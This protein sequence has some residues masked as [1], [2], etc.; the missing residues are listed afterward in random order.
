MKPSQNLF[1]KFLSISAFTLFGSHGVQA[2]SLYWDLN[3]T[4]ANSG[5]SATG[6]WNGTNQFWN[7]AS[8]GTGGASQAGTASA[9]DLIFS[10]GTGYTAGG[11]IT[12]SNARVASSITFEENAPYTLTGG[13]S[14]TIGGSG[15]SGF[16]GIRVSAGN[17]ATNGI[18][19][20]LIL[21]TAANTI[22]TAGTGVLTISGGITGTKA[23]VLANNSTNSAGISISTGSL[24]NTSTVTHSGTGT[25]GTLIS[26]VI[27]SNVTGVTQNSGT[28]NLTLTGANIFTTLTTIT[29][30]VLN[31][32]NATALGTTATGT[33]VASGAALELQSGIVVGAEALTLSG[34]GVSTAGAL[35]N[36]S[37]VNTYGGN[38]TLA[39]PSRINSDADTLTLNGASGITGAFGLTVGG[40]GDTT[41]SSVIGTTSGTL[42]KDGAG[43]LTLSGANTFTG[44]TTITAGVIN[45]QN[46][47]GL[48]TT[49]TGTTVAGG[50]ALELQGG[51]VVGAEALT[52]SGTGVS[53][54]GALRNIS[55]VNTYG[56]DITLAAPSRI[57]SDA[58]TLTLN[59]ASGITGAFGLSVG[60]ASDT[61]IS[62]VI[63]TTSGTLTKDGAGILTLSGANTYSG[64]TTLSAG[65]LVFGSSTVGSPGSITS[66]PLG[67]GKLTINGGTIA[68]SGVVRTVANAV[69]FGGNFT[70]DGDALVLD[71]AMTLQANTAISNISQGAGANTI[72]TLGG[73]I[74]AS[75][76]GDNRVLTITGPTINGNPGTDLI[77]NGNIG[78]SQA[79]KS[80]TVSNIHKVTT[81]DVTLNGSSGSALSITGI[82]QLILIGG[83][84]T[85]N[86]GNVTLGS[87]GGSG[88]VGVQI[89]SGKTISTG[90]G[91]VSLTGQGTS[92]GQGFINS[93]TIQSTT[94]NIAITATGSGTADGIVLGYS[95]SNGSVQTTSGNIIITGTG[96]ISGGEGIR[97]ISTA[98][99]TSTNGRITLEGRGG[100]SGASL[101]TAAGSTLGGGSG[102]ITLIATSGSAG[103]LN[104]VISGSSK[105]IKLGPV[106]LNLTAANT[107][108]GATVVGASND[109]NAGT[110][111]LSGS[112]RIS[113]AATT[114]YGGTLDL[115]GATQSITTLE[116]GGGASGSAAAVSIGAG[117]LKL[118]GNVTYSATNDPN[119][120]SISSSTGFL[121]LMG[122]R[123]FSVGN[124]SATADLTVSA[125][126]QNGDATARSL[127]KDGVGT[128]VLSG[129]NTYTG[130]TTVHGGTL[131]L[132]TGGSV[133][134][135]NI[136]VGDAGSSGSILDAT[137]TSLA[138]G[139]GKTLSGIGTIN[140]STTIQLGGTIAPGN[141]TGILTNVGNLALAIGSNFNM[142]LNGN[143]AGTGYDQL[144]VNG[145]V[146]LNG[147]N[148]VANFIG[149]AYSTGDLLFLLLNDGTDAIG[150]TGI[151]SGLAQDAFVVNYGGYDWKISY[152][153]DSASNTFTGAANGNDI[154]LMAVPETSTALL[155]GIGALLLLRRRRA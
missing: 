76:S 65:S 108:T 145:G 3:M 6:A 115:N 53:T 124:A 14:L 94:G 92:N 52:L 146:T 47:T 117:E 59:G 63:G 4:V 149:G 26:S 131:K 25:G 142:E 73:N 43:I 49:A 85:T 34:T 132:A 106:Q 97:I 123:T 10:S 127:T 61:T 84:V 27:G 58:G 37:G 12:L 116:L 96:G 67:T 5:T 121:S 88:N 105:L 100:V 71:G 30:G 120:A 82:D 137:A 2:L 11:T 36:I 144:R 33:T 110:L 35:R 57:N 151:F 72:L 86:G 46:A 28:S 141:S 48:G 103:T 125:I 111:R 77:I 22:Q 78:D 81:K 80:V 147:G 32:Q 21:A 87:L 69:D 62:S 38:I 68:A 66:G 7:T 135:T 15:A 95:A 134:S 29:A 42:T 153:A 148:L 99:I 50:A 119:G 17:N 136:I 91:T 44:L 101:F 18:S 113:T 8:T 114:V 104:G 143:V 75:A 109:V 79:L 152:N 133:A 41:I 1:V 128:M 39:A 40:A 129:A 45:I 90:T 155:G 122:N 139:S 102:D 98:G 16:D 9:D 74:N 70:I 83:N 13:T 126:I 89:A 112:G 31:I 107:Y 93:G 20:P 24:N 154:A 23:L 51:I 64:G 138:I 150:G 118:G 140:G 19:T 54:A 60:G 55:G 56:G 130:A